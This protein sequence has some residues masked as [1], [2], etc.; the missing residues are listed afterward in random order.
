MDRE[1]LYDR[2]YA[3]AERI[4]AKHQPCARCKSPCAYFSN[5]SPVRS[6]CCTNCPFLGADGCTIKSLACKLWLCDAAAGE[7]PIN[8]KM[9]LMSR[10]LSRLREIAI[11]HH[12]HY[13]RATRE[14]ALEAKEKGIP[15]NT[16][17][18]YHNEGRHP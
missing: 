8:K 6:G 11:V 13:A 18:F 16:W 15:N 1:Q 10:Q 17:H 4:L 5:K 2:L 7:W 9:H 12:I 3:I 14:E